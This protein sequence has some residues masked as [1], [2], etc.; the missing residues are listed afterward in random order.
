[1]RPGRGR[2]RTVGATAAPREE[3]GRHQA[4]G[5]KQT[6]AHGPYLAKPAARI[7]RSRLTTMPVLA[8]NDYLAKPSA[9]IQAATSSGR[10]VIT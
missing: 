5:D 4:G 3:A 2:H 9:R 1:V 7:Q 10:S 8:T 6:H